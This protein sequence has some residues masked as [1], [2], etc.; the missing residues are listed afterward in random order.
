MVI[1]AARYYRKTAGGRVVCEL[2]PLGCSIAEGKLGKCLGRMNRGGALYAIN[3][4]QAASVALDPIEKKPLYHFYPG[5]AILS[6][7]PN[8]C[9]MS[10]QF[11]QNWEISQTKVA[12][13]SVSPEQLIRLARNRD[14][15][16]L[17]YT[18]S[19]P[20]VWFEFLVDCAAKFKEAN[21]KN[22]LVTNGYINREPLKELLPLVDAMNID[23]KA[24][25][26][27]FYKKCCRAKLEPVLE[28]IAAAKLSCHVE[29]TN[30]II[31]GLNDSPELIDKL[32]DFVSNL[33]DDTPL[34]FSAYFPRY[35]FKIPPTPPDA[36][37]R[38]YMLARDRL[39]YVYIGNLYL[40][41]ASDTYCHA[42]GA[43]LIV[44]RGYST[45]IVGLDGV[46]CSRCGARANIIL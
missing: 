35:K 23:L 16:G 42:C 3:Y 44:R 7:G 28:T 39:K 30:L 36:L 8:G 40:P 31:P 22:V 9:N 6:I 41:G 37:K 10:C 24:M 18:Y 25:D 33:G 38:A 34:H 12:T 27:S 19:E 15:V 32:I 13:Q 17:S 21:L 26:A 45:K 1:I 29:I 43:V 14:S 46:C 11:C 4:G 2:C 5:A 20:L